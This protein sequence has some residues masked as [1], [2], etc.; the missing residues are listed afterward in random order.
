MEENI[1]N[2][3]NEL[4]EYLKKR[5]TQNH[6]LICNGFNINLGINTGYKEIFQRMKRDYV[7]YENLIIDKDYIDLEHIIGDLKSEIKENAN[8]R[9]FIEKFIEDK[10]KL[11]FMKSSYS[12]VK[13][14]IK[15][16]Y[17]EDRN[18]EIGILF[19]NFE[20]FFTLNYDP[21]LY[22]LLM[23]FK[24]TETT[25]IFSNRHNYKLFDIEVKNPEEFKLAKK[26]L[27]ECSKK[28]EDD[29]RNILNEIPL[30]EATKKELEMEIKRIFRKRGYKYKEEIIK[31]LLEDRNRNHL[32]IYD[33]FKK[34]LFVDTEYYNP[35]NVF[36]LHGA[37]HIYK[38]GKSVKKITQTQNE[39]FYNRLEEVT[40]NPKEEVITIFSNTDKI[41]EINQSDYL[42]KGL[43]KLSDLEG[44]IL[45]LG[46]SFDENDSH[47][48]EAINNSNIKN[49]YTD[50]YYRDESEKNRK[51]DE[52]LENLKLLFPDKNIYLFDY[53]T[54]S[55]KI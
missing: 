42:K 28:V 31:I 25:I 30:N 9:T 29:D 16:I 41:D 27:D 21:L 18:L 37:F 48:Y 43:K 22:L 26:I 54:I 10:V 7:G 17:E 13:D 52:K 49:I 5:E 23:K 35:Q 47:I 8:N 38:N 33:G 36:F 32:D 15:N 51:F 40:S 53:N 4:L 14:N 46:S 2:N 55:F 34:D 1:L 6:L 24:R 20:N 3:Y 50:L 44:S 45:I 12:I 39:A 19:K 11:D